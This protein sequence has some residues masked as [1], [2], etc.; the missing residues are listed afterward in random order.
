MNFTPDQRF[1]RLFIV[2][3]TLIIT[4][5]ILWNVSL[6]FEQ[7][8]KAERDRME[9]WANSIEALSETPLDSEGN[10]AAFD[11]ISLIIDKN[12]T[13]PILITDNN[14][15]VLD[16]KNVSQELLN[17]PKK[18]KKLLAQMESENEPL[19]IDLLDGEPQYAYYGHSPI[20]NQLQYFPIALIIVLI[21]FV[22]FIYFFYATSK[23]S[24]QNLL[25]AGMAKETAHQIGTPLSSL[26]GW[27]EILKSEDVNPEYVL[28]ME[29]DIQR[30]EVIAA[31]F[32]K[33]GSLPDLEPLDFIKE[34]EETF[35]YLAQRSSKLINFKFDKPQGVLMVLLNKELFSWTIENLVKNAI[36]AMKGKGSLTVTIKR[37]TRFA[38]VQ[39][40]DT[41]KGMP[42]SQF[43]K[44]FE[45]GYTTKKR[46]WGLGLSLAKRIIEDY[47]DGNIKVLNSEIGKGTTFEIALKLKNF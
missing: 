39:I 4:G 7:L 18:V 35:Q 13:I 6:F 20:I 34:T 32:S 27:A 40:T 25:W 1:I 11:L 19:E 31:R 43:T 46:G 3:A 23:V 5:F 30:L 37:D 10:D 26:L 9:V 38:K 29:K 33:I 22:A 17:D 44:V 42:K 21:L 41:G 14:L 16:G 47:H 15:N 28:E 2:I 45:P 12:T 24:E 8:K 36:D